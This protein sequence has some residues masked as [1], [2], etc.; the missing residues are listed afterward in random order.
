MNMLG[1]LLSAVVKTAI[2]PVAIV[3]DTVMILPETAEGEELMKRTSGLL[4]SIESDL[5]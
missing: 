2:L 5:K 4:S 1:N 3:A